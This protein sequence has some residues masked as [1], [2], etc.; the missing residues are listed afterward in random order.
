MCEGSEK[1][2]CEEQQV[3]VAGCE[4]RT[5]KSGGGFCFPRISCVPA[6]CTFFQWHV[7]LKNLFIRHNQHMPSKPAPEQS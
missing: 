5:S 1:R 7:F 3:T 4:E 6:L 2:R